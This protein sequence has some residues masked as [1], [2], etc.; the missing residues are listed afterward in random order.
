MGKLKSRTIGK[1]LVF[2]SFRERFVKESRRHETFAAAARRILFRVPRGFETY[3]ISRTK[4][5]HVVLIRLESGQR[6]T[7]DA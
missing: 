3:Q 4:D 7:Q 5:V 6:D 2:P 1:F